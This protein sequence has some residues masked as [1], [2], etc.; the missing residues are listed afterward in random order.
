M[1]DS[2]SSAPSASGA[3]SVGA[4][5]TTGGSA[6]VENALG[7]PTQ[8]MGSLA[9]AGEAPSIHPDFTY[10]GTLKTGD[11][12][13]GSGPSNIQKAMMEGRDYTDNVNLK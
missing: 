13:P 4:S 6:I 8:G 11:K 12:L 10:L 9:A 3:S 1:E 7:T 2:F 5:G